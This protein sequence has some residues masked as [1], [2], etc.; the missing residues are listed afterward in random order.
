MYI[1]KEEDNYIMQAYTVYTSEI[2]GKQQSIVA[3][4]YTIT[5]T[6]HHQKELPTKKNQ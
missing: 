4:A 1:I 2:I 5:T 3:Q 6:K